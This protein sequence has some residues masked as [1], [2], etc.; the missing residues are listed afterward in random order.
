MSKPDEHTDIDR[1]TCS[2]NAQIAGFNP[3][4]NLG[5]FAAL[6]RNHFPPFYFIPALHQHPDTNDVTS[7]PIEPPTRKVLRTLDDAIAAA[8]TSPETD[9]NGTAPTASEV[10]EEG[11]SGILETAPP[12][13]EDVQCSEDDED[14]SQQRNGPNKSLLSV[15]PTRVRQLRV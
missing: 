2:A 5:F 9:N 3:K 13:V 8:D 14:A 15:S 12:P 7:S 11:E 10:T 4:D 1:W 6:R